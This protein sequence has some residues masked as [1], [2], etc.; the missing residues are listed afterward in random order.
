MKT[1]TE[2]LFAEGGGREVL[3][4]DDSAPGEFVGTSNPRH[5]RVLQALLRR[6]MPREHIDREAGCSNGPDLIAELRRR[7]LRIPCER[8]P[9]IDRDGRIVERGI[10]HFNRGD[11][12]RLSAW[13]A[14][15]GAKNG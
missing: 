11:R 14:K 5:L 13:L 2:N 9:V 12:Q 10:Y 1:A 7:G 15:R 8:A 4:G 6:P 3:R